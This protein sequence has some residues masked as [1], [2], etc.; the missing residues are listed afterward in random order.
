MHC[1]FSFQVGKVGGIVCYTCFPYFCFHHLFSS[2][3][4]K[5]IDW[6]FFFLLKHHCGEI[7]LGCIR[8]IE[9]FFSFETS[10]S[11]LLL[12]MQCSFVESV[13]FFLCLKVHMAA[14]HITQAGKKMLWDNIPIM[15][16][17]SIQVSLMT[18]SHSELEKKKKQKKGQEEVVIANF[19]ALF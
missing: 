14:S 8:L 16:E 17:S 7:L 11:H 12:Q 19:F 9:V 18:R 10:Q 1:A 4:L 5:I 13:F 15:F 2:S 6:E 3:L